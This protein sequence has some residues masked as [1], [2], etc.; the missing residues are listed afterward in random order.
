MPSKGSRCTGTS[1]VVGV[2]QNLVA[3]RDDMRSEN[4]ATLLQSDVLQALA[5]AT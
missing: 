5:L 1:V 4:G 2:Q 3:D